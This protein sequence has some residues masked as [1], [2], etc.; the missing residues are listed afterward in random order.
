[1]NRRSLLDVGGKVA[2]AGHGLIGRRDN[3]FS[4]NVSRLIDQIIG[5]V[6]DH[7]FGYWEACF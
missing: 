1:M 7:V 3:R 5:P 6:I 2:M 4:V